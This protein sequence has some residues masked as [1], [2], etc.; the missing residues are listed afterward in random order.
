LEAGIIPAFLGCFVTLCVTF[1]GRSKPTLS[2]GYEDDGMFL[3]RSGG[4]EY[5][6]L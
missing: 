3:S 5:L 6:F 1:L 4:L 2:M